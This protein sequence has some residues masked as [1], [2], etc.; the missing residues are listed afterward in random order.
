MATTVAGG[1]AAA[2]GLTTTGHEFGSKGYMRTINLNDASI[3]PL[4]NQVGGHKSEDKGKPPYI[5]RFGEDRVLKVC[6]YQKCVCVFACMRGCVCVYVK[7]RKIMD[8][9]G[10]YIF[11]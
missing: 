4:S 5:L 2:P 7:V 1:T 9:R 3:K 8:Y 6:L 11:N 10:E